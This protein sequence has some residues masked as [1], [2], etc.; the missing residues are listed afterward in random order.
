MN[1]LTDSDLI[2]LAQ[3]GGRDKEQAFRLMVKQYGPV[4]YRQIRFITKN[5]TLTDDILQD[6]FV[7]VFLNLDSFKGDSSI[8]TWLY[9]IARNEALN[10]LQ[11]E[12]RRSGVDID[13][14]VIELISGT[15]ELNGVDAATIQ[16]LLLKAISE[17][18]EKQAVVFQLKYFEDM[19]YSDMSKLL[20]TSEGALKANYFHAKEKIADFLQNALNQ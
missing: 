6:V 11:K 10:T 19:K 1:E 3:R 16:D 5:E 13:E 20:N 8:Y 17:L 18:P 7:K 4:L 2:A 15:Q 9:R 12:K 14:T